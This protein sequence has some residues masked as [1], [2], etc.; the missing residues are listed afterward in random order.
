MPL[1]YFGSLIMK[2]RIGGLDPA[3]RNFGMCK[4]TLDTVQDG[5]TDIEINLVTTK[6]NPKKSVVRKNI[7]D[8]NCAKTLLEAT[9]TF[10][11]DVDVI[12]VEMPV[13]SQSAASMKSYGMCI[14]ICAALEKPLIYVT[15]SEVKLYG[16]GNK[17]ATKQQMIDWAVS[18]FPELPWLTH[19][20]NGKTILNSSNEH[21]ADALAAVIAGV[22]SDQFTPFKILR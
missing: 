4:G 22:N 1:F 7:L 6:A 14:A 21:M 9:K 19:K 11:A 10:M 13:G 17:N 2:I 8:L 20:K 3:M 12:C 15:A 16:H 5:F 18:E